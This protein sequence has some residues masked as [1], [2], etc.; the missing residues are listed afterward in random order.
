MR[1]KKMEHLSRPSKGKAQAK[2]KLMFRAQ[3]IIKII[4]K[5]MVTGSTIT[6]TLYS[7]STITIS[8][9]KNNIN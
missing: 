5:S 3:N 1:D 6:V 9:L 8:K 2:G 7:F 4:F